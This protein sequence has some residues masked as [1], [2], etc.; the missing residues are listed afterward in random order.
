MEKPAAVDETAAAKAQVYTPMNPKDVHFGNLHQVLSNARCSK[1]GQD[2]I[3]HLEK[4]FKEL[5]LHYPDRALEKFE[6]VSFLIKHGKDLSEFLKTED[7]RD[8]KLL[9]ADLQE[10]NAKVKALFELPQAEEEGEEPPEIAPV[11]FVQDLLADSR[12]F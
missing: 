12:I 11:G 5:I 6:E 2:L 1:T 3:S 7:W 9:S 4:V 8:Y 10:Y